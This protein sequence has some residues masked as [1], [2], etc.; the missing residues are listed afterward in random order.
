MVAA[1]GDAVE[2][3]DLLVD[4]VLLHVTHQT[5]RELGTEDAGV[6]RLLV[7]WACPGS[8]AAGSCATL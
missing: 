7:H 1:D 3:A 5:Q 4:E 2:V 6:L 8:S